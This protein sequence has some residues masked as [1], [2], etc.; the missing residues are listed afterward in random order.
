MGFHFRL[1]VVGSGI[2]RVLTILLFHCSSPAIEIGEARQSCPGRRGYDTKFLDSSMWSLGC[3]NAAQEAG[4]MHQPDVAAQ[5]LD[6]VLAFFPRADAKASVLL[7]VDTGM[8]AVLASNCPSLT[9]FDWWMLI[10]ILPLVLLGISLLQLY[11]GA[12]PSLKGGEESLIYFREI[13]KKREQP[14]IEAFIAQTETAYV[15]DLLGQ[16]W[17]NSEILKMKFDHISSAFN[18]MALALVPWL[19]SLVLLTIHYPSKGL[20]F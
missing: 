1:F 3:Y 18:F 5:Q 8:L 11:R 10:P 19:G 9:A 15:K 14:F 13:A 17:R 20:H 7:A 2:L 4:K 6:R 12:F 16:V